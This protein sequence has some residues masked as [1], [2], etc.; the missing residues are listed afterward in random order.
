M[1]I[2][3]LKKTF[4]EELKNVLAVYR[5][6]EKEKLNIT[7]TPEVYIN[8]KSTPTEV[9]NWLAAKKFSQR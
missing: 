4:Q 9:R 8:Q 3:I 1:L 5:E 7:K 2:L 6:K